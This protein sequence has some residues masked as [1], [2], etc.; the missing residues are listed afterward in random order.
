VK[1]AIKMALGI[2]LGAIAAGAMLFYPYRTK[3]I[4]EWRLQVLDSNGKPLAGVPVSEDWL[5]PIDEGNSTSDQKKTEPNGA[6]AFPQR[7]LHSRLE[8]A[9][10]GIKPDARIQLCTNEE[11]GAVYWDGSG[12][13]PS[14]LKLKKGFCPYD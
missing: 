7:V 1:L 8:F 13:P 4:P 11:F 14:T 6:V 9:F 2:P 12:P 3:G 10:Q 5:D